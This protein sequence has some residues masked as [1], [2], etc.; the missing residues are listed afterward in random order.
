MGSLS[1]Y[2]GEFTHYAWTEAMLDAINEEGPDG[3]PVKGVNETL[4]KEESSRTKL[5]LA[6][7]LPTL[8]DEVKDNVVDT[9]L[10]IDH[11]RDLDALDYMAERHKRTVLKREGT[12]HKGSGPCWCS[13]II[14]TGSECVQYLEPSDL[15]TAEDHIAIVMRPW[16][17][18]HNSDDVKPEP[19]NYSPEDH[20]REVRMCPHAW[21]KKSKGRDLRCC[22]GPDE[23]YLAPAPLK[24]ILEDT[25]TQ[26][27]D[28]F[29][30]I[31][32]KGLC[33]KCQDKNEPGDIDWCNA[34]YASYG[35][36][37]SDNEKGIDHLL[38][39]KPGWHVTEQQCFF[40]DD[41]ACGPLC[42]DDPIKKED[43]FEERN[44]N[45]QCDTTIGKG[46]KYSDESFLAATADPS[47]DPDLA[48]WKTELESNGWT[49]LI[50]KVQRA[51]P[52]HSKMRQII[53][54]YPPP[55]PKKG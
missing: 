10:N 45:V 52:G 46:S 53:S 42:L 11:L 35:S 39:R 24:S 13:D 19:E 22:K 30:A 18:Y 34:P 8:E 38:I 41:P 54:L 7:W 37:K 25:K 49:E 16:G 51:T 26:A 47:N 32:R 6:R 1:K 31:I 28:S 3:E 29:A 33:F 21:T 17:L 15:K 27:D 43:L 44:K 50:R 14:V 4:C 5:S 2:S 12:I 23:R 20:F 9:S 55:K 40:P 48:N 36:I